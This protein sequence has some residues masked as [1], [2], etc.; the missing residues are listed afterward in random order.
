MFRLAAKY[1]EDIAPALAA[2]NPAM[3]GG[4]RSRPAATRL[5]CLARLPQ[6]QFVT[7]RLLVQGSPM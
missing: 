1:R 7:V 2:E 6:R 5:C 4:G 3:P